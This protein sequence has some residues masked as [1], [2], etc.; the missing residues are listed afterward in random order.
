MAGSGCRLRGG[1]LGVELLPQ[2]PH[3][4]L[5]GLLLLTQPLRRQLLGEGAIFRG[6]SAVLRPARA[7]GARDARGGG[8]GAGATTVSMSATR[9]DGRDARMN[10]SCWKAA[11][12]RGHPPR[13]GGGGDDDDKQEELLGLGL[14]LTDPGCGG[15]GE[16]RAHDEVRGGEGDLGRGEV[17][18]RLRAG[19]ATRGGR[20]SR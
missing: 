1:P 4:V 7:R 16:H 14:G 9:L 10:T 3:D 12:R 18:E 13:K 15:A 8:G 5:C 2:P 19:E 6:S 11:H 17:E 20:I